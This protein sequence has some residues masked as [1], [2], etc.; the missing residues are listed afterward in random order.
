L[1]RV[2]IHEGLRRIIGQFNHSIIISDS[3][4]KASLIIYHDMPTAQKSAAGPLPRLQSRQTVKTENGAFQSRAGITEFSGR[5]QESPRERRN[6]RGEPNSDY[7]ESNS[8]LGY[9]TKGFYA[10]NS[11]SENHNFAGRREVYSPSPRT[12]SSTKQSIGPLQS[13]KGVPMLEGAPINETAP[14]PE[15]ADTEPTR[16]DEGENPSTADS[17]YLSKLEQPEFNT[18]QPTDRYPLEILDTWELFPN[19]HAVDG[20][21]ESLLTQG[22]Q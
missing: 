11:L 4:K 6:L 13:L 22:D 15:A 14:T 19:D 3:E 2:N 20:G 18:M 8:Y 9:K 21:S 17:E 5:T 10:P 16:G 1:K 12:S 7:R